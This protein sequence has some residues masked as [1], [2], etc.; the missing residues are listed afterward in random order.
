[1]TKLSQ[2]VAEVKSYK[3]LTSIQQ[4]NTAIDLCRKARIKGLTDRFRQTFTKPPSFDQLTPD[5]TQPSVI[6]KSELEQE[7]LTQT[8]LLYQ[9]RRDY[10][11]P[12]YDDTFRS[13][14]PTLHDLS[15]IHKELTMNAVNGGGN[16]GGVPNPE[17]DNGNGGNPGPDPPNN[18]GNPGPDPPNNGG[19]PGP[20]PPNN[21]G[22]DDNG[23]DNGGAGNG[24]AGDGDSE[25]GD[26]G[27]ENGDG[28]GEP[29]PDQNRPAPDQNQMIEQ[30]NQMKALMA[31]MAESID[32]INARN[33]NMG[34]LLNTTR[35]TQDREG[36]R[37]DTLE[38]SVGNLINRVTA[39]TSDPNPTKLR[40]Y[41]KDKE[42]FDLFENRY[43]SMWRTANWSEERALSELIQNL[44]T[45]RA[46]RVVRSKLISEWTAATLLEACRERLGADLTL[47]QVQAQLYSLEPKSDESPDEAMCRVEDVIAKAQIDDLERRELN[48]VQRQAFLRLIHIHE[49]MYYYVNENS[50]STSDP[51]DALTLAKKYLR[52][53]GHEAD[54]FTKL[55]ERQLE[56]RGIKEPE[57]D[58]A[59]KTDSKSSTS[60]SKKDSVSVSALSELSAKVDKLLSGSTASS[61]VATVDARYLPTNSQPEDWYKKITATLNEHERK[62]RIMQSEFQKMVEGL[63]SAGQFKQNTDQAQSKTPSTNSTQRKPFKKTNGNGKNQKSNGKR[64][65]KFTKR[66]TGAVQVNFYGNQ[67][68]SDSS[69]DDSDH[70][71]QPDDS[72]QE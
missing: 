25:N 17:N 43:L 34:E 9:P 59:E 65:G 47:A 21:G 63:K 61:N 13:K 7:L 22:Q 55:V 15:V 62:S 19:N 32:G 31:R 23:A 51:Y 71:D 28:N 64:N 46:E 8:P 26:D 20:D 45:P 48:K 1:M 33:H 6:P 11:S 39:R 66:Q 54:Y 16:P 40:P 30:M 35:D 10:S 49:P 3:H 12:I 29:N 41:T 37:A 27:D 5:Q 42:N 58:S 56:K 44:Q 2:I 50:I 60:T 70:E 36:R 18:G 24:G 38:R 4:Y 67:D 52:T 57:A 68:E 69:Q 14:L 72:T 53:R